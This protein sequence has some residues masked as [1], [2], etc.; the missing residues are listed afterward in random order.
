MS[1]TANGGGAPA[2]AKRKQ[3]RAQSGP[4]VVYAIVQVLDEQGQPMKFD[5]TRIRILDVDTQAE[6][7]LTTVEASEKDHAFFI[8]SVLRGRTPRQ[9]NTST[10]S[11]VTQSSSPR[12]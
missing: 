3:Q 4:R 11:A 12:R 10:V 9:G 6:R 1:D 5:K 8:R 7:M 2:P